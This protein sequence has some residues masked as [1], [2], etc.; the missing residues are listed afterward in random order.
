MAGQRF[1][2]DFLRFLMER[3]FPRDWKVAT[4]LH[5][6]LTVGTSTRRIWKA[7]T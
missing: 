3:I 4:Y 1:P 7:V 6:C 2:D 5:P